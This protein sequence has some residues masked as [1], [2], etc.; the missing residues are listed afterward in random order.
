MRGK[1]KEEAYD[2]SS[3]M[4]AMKGEFYYVGDLFSCFCPFLLKQI[5]NLWILRWD[6]EK[7]L[8]AEQF[9]IASMA[10]ETEFLSLQAGFYML[11]YKE[12]LLLNYVGLLALDHL[13]QAVGRVNHSF[14]CRIELEPCI[15]FYELSF[16]Y[17]MRCCYWNAHKCL[18]SP[19]IEAR[20][21]LIQSLS[22]CL[23]IHRY[24]ALMVV[25]APVVTGAHLDK[26]WTK[27]GGGVPCLSC[28]EEPS[29]Y[30]KTTRSKIDEFLKTQKHPSSLNYRALCSS[31]SMAAHKI[32]L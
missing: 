29:A 31:E 13:L 4:V 8:T 24:L 5:R 26:E 6:P 21:G 17:G 32:L 9:L 15:N 23:R 27:G 2:S 3:T 25:D 20:N 30:F 19:W 10:I 18:P 11:E 16:H 28:Q 14:T 7:N 1:K 22:A 12:L